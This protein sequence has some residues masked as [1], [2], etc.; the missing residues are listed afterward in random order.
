MTGIR[1]QLPPRETDLP[2]I[3]NML[4][5]NTITQPGYVPNLPLATTQSSIDQRPSSLS[6][7]GHPT[8]KMVQQQTTN[9]SPG[10]PI[11]DTPAADLALMVPET[12]YHPTALSALGAKGGS[13]G[14][15]LLALQMASQTQGVA[16][17][18]V[19]KLVRKTSE[20]A[21]LE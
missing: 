11:L 3:D 21:M 1:A 2:N 20:S 4:L 13:S 10:V 9:N 12:Q 14:K 15:D 17:P 18:G 19:P 7:G 8:A 16:L 6:A 5:P